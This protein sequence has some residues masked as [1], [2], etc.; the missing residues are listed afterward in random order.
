LEINKLIEQ[1]ADEI[2]KKISSESKAPYPISETS[3][4]QKFKHDI[5]SVIDHTLLKPDASVD[6]ITKLCTEAKKYKFASVCVNPSFVRLVS[7]LLVGSGVKACTVIGF[8]LGAN[9]THTKME[10]ANE[11]ISNGANEIDMVINIGAIKSGSWEIVKND[12]QGVVNVSK[13]KALVKVILETCLL[14]D[15]EKVKACQICKL[16][17]A[18]FVKTST[19]FSTGGATV[20]DITLMRKVVGENMGV[21]ASGAVKD[22]P[23]ALSMLKAGASRIGTSSGVAIVDAQQNG[24]NME[25][26]SSN[27]INCGKCSQTCPTGNTTIVKNCY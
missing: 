7:Q 3:N 16:A 14:N 26:A 4:H 17:G 6:Q 24:N 18:D 22:Y 19:G 11:A 15:E 1:I 13:G 25:L 5:A 21:K 8:P 10:E 23:T 27:C 9:T 20:E 2:Y 12:I